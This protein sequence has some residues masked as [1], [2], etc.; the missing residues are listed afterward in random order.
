MSGATFPVGLGTL[1]VI[2]RAIP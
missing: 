1:Q 2:H